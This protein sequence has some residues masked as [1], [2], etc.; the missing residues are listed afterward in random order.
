MVPWFVTK[1]VT[2]NVVSC[3]YG[4]GLTIAGG[5]R[6][7]TDRKLDIDGNVVNHGKNGA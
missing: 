5:L 6:R 2:T 7:F 1:G 4:K 3:N